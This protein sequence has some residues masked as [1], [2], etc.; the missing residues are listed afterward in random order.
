MNTYR[1]ESPL[2]AE[3]IVNTRDTT[4][5]EPEYLR[6]PAELARYLEHWNIPVVQAPDAH[7][8]TEVL[9]LRDRLRAVFEASSVAGA[10]EVLNEL[11]DGIL[12]RPHIE[13]TPD[14]SINLDLVVEQDL[15]IARRLAAEAAFGLCAALAQYGIER[16]HVC[17]AAPC[18]EVFLD[19]S[20]NHTRRYCCIQCANRHNV[21]A[22]R[23]RHR[24]A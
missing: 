11:L 19:T 10:V 9:L 4:R 8:L 3:Q 13:L 23:Q 14:G 20:R 18:T 24:T 2:L 1:H 16:L 22:H 15:P 12:V 7:D 21:A 17:N 5:P 6:E